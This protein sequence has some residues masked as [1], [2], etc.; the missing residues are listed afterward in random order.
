MKT[1]ISQAKIIN[2]QRCYV[3]SVVIDGDRIAY[4][5]NEDDI[6]NESFDE[7]IDAKGMIL[8]PGVID[9]HVHFREPGLTHKA[10]I[11]SES[12]AAAAGGVTSYFDMPNCKPQ[13]TTIETLQHKRDIAS[14]SSIVNHAFFF[15]ATADNYDLI[16]QLPWGH[17]PGVKLFM[18]SS[19]GNMLVDKEE[20]LKHIFG[21]M[22][23][24]VL[25]VHCEDTDIINRNMQKAKLQ[26]GDDVPVSMHPQIRSAKACLEST[27]LAVRLANQYGTRLHIAHISTHDELELIRK[28]N[29]SRITTEACVGH[30]FFSSED[31][32]SKGALIKVNP[33]IKDRNERDA[34]RKALNDDTVSVIGTDHA[35]HLF[36]EKQGGADKATSGMPILQFSLPIMLELCDEGIITPQRMVELMCHKP[37]QLFAIRDRGFIRKG[38]KAD[39][40]LI[41]PDSKWTLTKDMILSKCGWSPL[42]GHTFTNKVI[43]TIV[44]G[45]TVYADGEIR[46][47]NA[48]EELI[49]D[50]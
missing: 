33:A 21:I 25:M 24:H 7:V 22:D 3:A 35:P 26:Y 15:G 2:E 47:T 36:D 9:D 39:L 12:R 4:V 41:N 11:A 40:V 19:T 45:K 32:Q 5:G 46:D 38:Y 17:I 23:N 29:N 16:P 14:K 10:D 49:F 27:K 28:N 43:R 42:E 18:G 30:L 13:T 44:N 31:H 50:N 8:I 6:D 48:A 37:A 1:L 34:L 20:S